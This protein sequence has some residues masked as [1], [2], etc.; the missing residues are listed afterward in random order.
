MKKK[1]KSMV[2]QFRSDDPSTYLTNLEQQKALLLET[3]DMEMER[4]NKEISQIQKRINTYVEP[5]IDENINKISESRLRYETLRSKRKAPEIFEKNKKEM[6][7]VQKR[8]NTKLNYVEP[9]I[10]KDLDHIAASRLR[11]EALKKTKAPE[12]IEKNNSGLAG[13]LAVSKRIKD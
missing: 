10:N 9:E 3:I 8:I 4:N 7:Q 5:E 11:Y 6:S 2:R 13:I 12:K 1:N